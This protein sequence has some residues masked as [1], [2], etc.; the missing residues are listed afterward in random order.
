ML[1]DRRSGWKTCRMP[2]AADD[3][4]AW[5]VAV[6]QAISK[7]WEDWP[8]GKSGQVRGELDVGISAARRSRTV[9][10]TEAAWQRFLGCRVRVVAG[11][12]CWRW[13]VWLRERAM[14]GQDGAGC[15]CRRLTVGCE[16]V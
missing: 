9:L 1:P 7:H 13:L 10:F 15:P 12:C 14:F 11:G 4:G 16:P 3:L 8:E 2:F 5:L 6:T